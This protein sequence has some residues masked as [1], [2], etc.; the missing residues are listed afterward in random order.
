M[1]STSDS[2]TRIL[3]NTDTVLLL[4]FGKSMLASSMSETDIKKLFR[5]SASSCEFVILCM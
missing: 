1:S 3:N 2:E 5:V 4:K